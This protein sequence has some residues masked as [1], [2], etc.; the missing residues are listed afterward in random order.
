MARVK[1]RR[2][3]ADAWRE[4]MAKFAGGGLSVREFCRREGISTSSF[5]WWRS[6]FNG[7]SRALPS[8]RPI[9]AAPAGEFVDLGTLSVPAASPSERFELRL[10][11]GGGVILHL[12]RG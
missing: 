7:G 6:R 12:L 4:L 1:R 8:A 11:L 9:A 3:G 2:L 10:D 5:N